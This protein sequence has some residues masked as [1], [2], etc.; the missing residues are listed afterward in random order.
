MAWNSEHTNA[1]KAFQEGRI[2][3]AARLFGKVLG[4]EESS[5]GWNDWAT[6]QF[7]LSNAEEAEEGYRRALELDDK[8]VE[9]A[10]N[11]GVLLKHANRNSEAIEWLEQ[12]VP[13]LT[14]PD[15]SSITG[16]LE[17]CRAGVTG[18]T[19]S[20]SLA[21]H[22]LNFAGKNDNERSY[23]QTH[24][25]RYVKT[26]ELL[27]NAVPGQTLLEL[28][29]A[30]HHLTPSLKALKGY[31]VRCSDVWEGSAQITR[32]V[33]SA[34]GAE[35][36]QISVDNFDVERFPWPYPDNSFDV[37]LCCE[38]LEHLITD[39]MG[40]IAEI[41]RVLKQNGLLLLTT[42][43]M[44]SAKS[45]EYALRGESP[46]IYGR[47]EPGG[48]PTDHHNREYTTNEVERLVVLGG[49]QVERIFT[50]DSWWNRDRSL[51]RLFA[52]RGLPV[53]R[54]GDNTLC[55][56]RKTTATIERYPEEFYL[57][58][59]TQA[60]R[61]DEQTGSTESG[62]SDTS[63]PLHVLIVNEMLPQPDR[64]GSDVRIMQIVRELREQGHQVTYLARNGHL[65]EHYTA[66]L[67]ELGVKVWAHD[68]E[69]LHYLGVDDP[70]EWTLEQV[71]EEGNFDL[72][73]LLMWF[74]S[75]TSVP[76]QYMGAIRKQSPNT[77]IAVLTDDQHG[78]RELRMAELNGNWTDFERAEDYS[79][80]EFE[81]YRNADI[82]LSIS[83]DDRR[84]LLAKDST[85]N[86]SLL[87]MR[88]ELLPDGRGFAEREGIL[89]LGNFANAANRDGADWMLREV[90]PLVR[91]QIPSATLS[92][93]G[94]NFPAGLGSQHEGVKAIGHVPDIQPLLHEHRI[95]V[96]PIRFGTG[97]KTKNLSALGSG[98][99]L[100]TTTIGAEGMNLRH[101]HSALIADAADAFAAEIVRSYRD[102]ILWQRLS[103]E[104]RRHVSVEFG[105]NRLRV[106]MRALIDQ[107]RAINPSA[108][109]TSYEPS[110]LTVEKSNPEV[111][112]CR[113]VRYRNWLRFTGYVQLAEK[114][115]EQN[116][117]RQALEQLRHIFSASRD[118]ILERVIGDQA[119]DLMGRCYSQ[120]GNE[121]KAREYARR[122]QEAEYT[123]SIVPPQAL[124]N[125]AK[126][127]GPKLSVIIPTH[128]RASQLT[129]CLANLAA[130]SLPADSWEVIVVDDGSTDH[131]PQVCEEFPSYC[132][133]EYLQ[134]QHTG[135]GVALRVAVERS[136]S[137]YLLFIKDD[138]V[139]HP[140]MLS[141]HLQAQYTLAGEK[142]AVLG[143]RSY[144]P[145]A[146]EN[147]LNLFIAQNPL[148]FVQSVLSPEL[149]AKKFY[150]MT[151]NLSIAKEI[152]LALGSFDAAFETAADIELGVRMHSAGF[153]LKKLAAITSDHNHLSTSVEEFVCK[154][155][156]FGKAQAQI[157]KKHPFLTG[158]GSGPFG[159]LDAAAVKKLH[160]L[161][162]QNRADARE[163]TKE[164]ER[165]N[166]IDLR[167][168]INAA[169]GAFK[170]QSVKQVVKEAVPVV[171]WTHFFASFLESWQE[172]KARAVS[173]GD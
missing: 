31:E 13:K 161:V 124:A 97:I 57:T 139:P 12:A 136:R 52:S 170:V 18:D 167:P 91:A 146:A 40:V 160:Q 7:H 38:M 78:L 148:F 162:K 165:V 125:V 123:R 30:F 8:N 108:H 16:M 95:F 111:L 82:V 77:R 145:E 168:Y 59:G 56:A 64:N 5:E 90:W 105:H 118:G 104:G 51:L 24:L 133:F 119:L 86:I 53:A 73:I 107:A 54:R 26:L 89:F 66:A 115:L 35:S 131:T 116:C 11:L 157:F 27:P 32:Q 87:P 134:Q 100:V 138:T 21:A 85:L 44:A 61:R 55:L 72:A 106:S 20:T 114:H 42:P 33:S 29:A 112:T 144:P 150:F 36:H 45:V 6:A 155:R 92:L 151:S 60:E 39:P 117:P 34:D 22:L 65:R 96:C 41:N 46:Y 163:R 171:Y 98:L 113:P 80:R 137:P 14:E 79:M 128:N 74:W 153:L 23:L 15:R 140:S 47:Y 10:V 143:S 2:E 70:V 166:A 172:G 9:A 120:L 93:A 94:S 154:A 158:D 48:R 68:S 37:V 76:E 126:R 81:V 84:G 127:S 67:E 121:N 132:R 3:E 141:D 122:K 50:Q 88:A 173:A 152:V 149:Q 83:E 110:Y 142:A 130:Q 4:E 169:D 103:R 43:N 69:R 63:E 17:E 75:S 19:S 28:G 147:A 99:P 101:G 49:F 1:L 156:R 71:L 25:S 109:N 129:V 159:K 102:S 164:L 58:L 135:I 62:D